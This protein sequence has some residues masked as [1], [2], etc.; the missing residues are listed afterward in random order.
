[1]HGP[2][3]SALVILGSLLTFSA[4]VTISATTLVTVNASR[5]GPANGDSAV[6]AISA[7]GRYVAFVSDASDL[8]PDDTNGTQDV[9]VRDLAKGV[10]MLVSRNHT[11]TASGNG[12]SDAPVMSGSGRYIAFASHASDLVEADTNGVQDVFVRDLAT[13]LTTLI[14]RDSAG[15]A[16]GNGESFGPS[17]SASGRSVAFVSFASNLVAGDTNATIDMFVRDLMTGATTLVSVNSSGTASGNFFTE[18]GRISAD[19]R[20]VAFSS[21]ASDLVA[22]DTNNTQ[23]VFVRNLKPGATSLVSANSAGTDSG[24]GSS[25]GSAID[26]K[27]RSVAFSSAASDLVPDG[28]GGGVFLRDLRAGATTRVSVTTDGMP[29]AGA[30]SPV[31]S[32]NGRSI[33]FLKVLY[34]FGEDVGTDVYVRDLKRGVTVLV[35]ESTPGPGVPN[36]A[37][38]S[39][40]ANGRFF[41]FVTAAN[42]L[43]GSDTNGGFDAFVYDL[44]RDLVVLASVNASGT[45][46]GNRSSYDA[47]VSANGRM[48]AFTSDASDLV[49]ADTNGKRDVFARALR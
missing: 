30:A 9:F 4:R 40:S 13:G 7:N 3:A 25:G 27:G 44:A 36:D 14:S 29:I 8:V 24:N 43:A 21:F 37:P 16:S 38:T 49:A 18:F 5:S 1:M 34:R 41:G 26:A 19:G 47:L 35:S 31:M 20:S 33:G 42:D 23:D 10:T 28:A 12:R 22:R 2:T 32:A 48:V 17:I 6:A 46:T 39:M 45:G 15:M 11:G